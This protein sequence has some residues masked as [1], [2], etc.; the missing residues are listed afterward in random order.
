MRAIIVEDN[1]QAADTLR[2]Y[3]ADYSYPVE[4]CGVASSLEEARELI[5]SKHPEIW[6]L[7]IRLHDQEIFTLLDELRQTNPTLLRQASIIFLTGYAEVGYYQKAFQNSALGYLTKPIDKNLFFEAMDKAVESRSLEALSARM[8]QLESLLLESRA[9]RITLETGQRQL[10]IKDKRDLVYIRLRNGIKY[11]RFKSE[12]E[13]SVPDDKSLDKW[14][15]ILGDHFI[16]S[17]RDEIIN[18]DHI[19]RIDPGE[20]ELLMSDNQKISPSRDQFRVIRERF[21]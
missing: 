16:K 8:E 4:I 3:L 14:Q 18:L 6:L 7:D 15:T 21:R 11:F 10:V 17:N 20:D 2:H 19:V 5:L 13:M 12:E 9:N 1:L